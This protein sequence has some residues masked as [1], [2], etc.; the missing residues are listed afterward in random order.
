MSSPFTHVMMRYTFA[1]DTVTVPSRRERA[2]SATM[3]EIKH[4]ALELMRQQGNTDVRFSD[5]ARA[6]GLT[7][8]ALYRYYAD[9]DE[10]L[11]DMI[12]DAY[13]DLGA[14]LV[15]PVRTGECADPQAHLQLVAGAYR[16]WALDDPQRFALIFGPPV[17]GYAAPEEGPT[18]EAA[19]GAM[20]NL[21]A[22]VHRAADN[23][24]LGV[25]IVTHVEAETLAGLMAEEKSGEIVGELSPATHQ[26]M[27]HAWAAMH[28][29]I[30]LEAYG[31]LDWFTPAAR[32]G[33][34]RTQVHLAGLAMGFA[35]PA[36]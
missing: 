14:A 33:L 30:C 29:F 22:V 34:F 26:A 24:V 21:A 9:R 10:L 17:P 5:I 18:V 35:A 3:A 20:A 16:A 27:L 2:R 23:G 11:T 19:Q 7:P 4:T 8:P 1:M 31:H 28:G 25:P 12:T 32:E 36:H 15:V 13:R 6:M